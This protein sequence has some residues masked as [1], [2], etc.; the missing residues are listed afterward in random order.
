MCAA[1][2]SVLCP[3]I[4][5]VQFDSLIVIVAHCALSASLAQWRGDEPCREARTMPGGP[6][7]LQ[8]TLRTIADYA[9]FAL[10]DEDIEAVAGAV[11]AARGRLAALRKDIALTEEPPSVFATPA[12]LAE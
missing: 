9:G 12:G 8:P 10:S 1:G 11:E 6:E 4:G 7:E 3:H 5:H 2:C